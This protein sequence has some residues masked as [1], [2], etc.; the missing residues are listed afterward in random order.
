MILKEIADKFASMEF[1]LN[2]G[3]YVGFNQNDVNDER[4]QDYAEGIDILSVHSYLF[5][6]ISIVVEKSLTKEKYIGYD[7]KEIIVINKIG[8]IFKYKTIDEFL[9]NVVNDFDFIIESR[10]YRESYKHEIK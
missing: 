4:Y 2:N 1:K 7:I 3:N 8:E 9:I 5:H 6:N 10:Y